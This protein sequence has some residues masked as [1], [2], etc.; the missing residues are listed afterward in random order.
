MESAR[1]PS[2]RI[3]LDK[4]RYDQ[5]TYMGRAK[6]FFTVTDPRNILRSAKEL[7]ESKQLLIKYRRG[8]E[9]KGTSD[10]QVWWAKKTYESAYHPDTGET[11]FIL[12]RMSAQVP[13]NMTITGCMMTFYRTTPAVLF[14]QWINQSFNAVVNYTNR[15]G[16]SLLTNKE[17][18]IAYA[19]ATSGAITVALGLNYATRGA[20]PLIGRFVPFA[21]VAAANCVNIPFMRQREIF[22]G[23][24]ITDKDG[25]RIGESK[26]AARK[27]IASVVF[28]RIGMAAPGMFLP[29]FIMNHLDSKPFMKRLPWLASPIQV[30]LVG[31]CLVFATP[32]CCAI[33]PQQSSIAVSHLEP[34][35]Q[36]KI[37]EK[38][39]DSLDAVFFNKGL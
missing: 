14:W 27:A 4:P 7:E 15:S 37:R 16:D 11:M 20:P 24:P 22:H 5:S 28:S 6:H 29:P 17:L 38:Y 34:E 19:L 30:L 31:F 36:A 12:G 8:E 26:A 23:I 25:N 10:E 32:L 33:F 21:A 1:L 18:S 3:D 35:L 9:P 39:G 13:M 2:G